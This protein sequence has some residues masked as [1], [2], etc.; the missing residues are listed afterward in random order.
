MPTI[1]IPRIDCGRCDGMGSLDK[2][3]SGTCPKCNGRKKDC[4][5]KKCSRCGGQGNTTYIIQVRCDSCRG[6][7]R[8][9]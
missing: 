5:G 9:G 3:V 7:G 8:V 2:V 1:Y 6:S 4:L